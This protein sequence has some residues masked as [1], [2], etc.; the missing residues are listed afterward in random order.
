ML[1]CETLREACG[2]SPIL[3]LD[4]PFA[5]LDARRAARILALLSDAGIG[6]TMLTVPRESEIPPEFTRLA[7]WRVAGGVVRA[8]DGAGA[9]A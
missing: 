2:A 7:R 8:P 6:Q 5:E 1:E 9:A 3:L 4:D